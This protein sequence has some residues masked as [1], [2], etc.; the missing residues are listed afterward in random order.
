MSLLPLE[1]YFKKVS[2][3]NNS[4]PNRSGEYFSKYLSILS[5]L[6]SNVYPQINVGLTINSDGVDKSLYTDHSTAHFDEVVK[7][8]GFLLGLGIDYDEESTQVVNLSPYEIFCLLVAIRIHD[9]GNILGR[10]GHSNACFLVLKDIYSRNS[11]DQTENRIIAKIAAAHGGVTNSG[12]KDTIGVLEKSKGVHAIAVREQLLAGILRI[13]DEI[14]ENRSRSSNYLMSYDM[15]PEANKL[16]HLYG[17]SITN[18]QYESNILM[19]EFSLRESWL[20]NKYR[21]EDEENFLI[22]YIYSRL[23]KMDLERIYC[24][25]FTKEVCSIDSIKVTLSFFDEDES[26]EIAEPLAIT[27]ED[28]GYPTRESP[29]LKYKEDYNGEAIQTKLRDR[30]R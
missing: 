5:Y 23:E 3:N 17:T 18:N 10:E 22:D 28:K 20:S 7:Y 6:K 2:Q 21:K 12:S 16:Y 24:N 25:R 4:F 11:F 14:C 29:L 26:H 27:L 1:M 30:E 13:S 9:A 15:I 8:A 19:L